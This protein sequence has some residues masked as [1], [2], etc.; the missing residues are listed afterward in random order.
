[1]NGSDLCSQVW[2]YYTVAGYPY[3]RNWWPLLWA[4]LDAAVC[5]T[6]KICYLLGD[7]RSHLEIQ[8]YIALRLLRNLAASLRAFGHP[9]LPAPEEAR[10]TQI[11]Q[12]INEHTKIK[13]TAL[14]EPKQRPWC[15]NCK[16]IRPLNYQMNA[17]IPLQERAIN[18]RRTAYPRTRTACKECQ[19][20]L[21]S[22]GPCWR[23]YHTARDRGE[24]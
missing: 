24:L 17:R 6:A 3:R 13:T 19:A 15:V 2:S 9:P 20:P 22:S 23:E 10:P 18:R 8:Q 1:M 4:L 12:P 5:N 11:S 21:C 7:Q 14:E 16:P